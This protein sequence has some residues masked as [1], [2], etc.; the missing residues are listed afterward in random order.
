MHT[1]SPQDQIFDLGLGLMRARLVQV[2]AELRIA[3][4]LAA[5]QQSIPGTH[6][7]FVDRF[8]R[9]C[10]TIGLVSTQPDGTFRLT[11]VGETLR[12]G[13]PGSMQAM[14]AS[15]L[16]GAHL[17]A[18]S[19][20]R[21]SLER[22]VTA[23]DDRHGED[24]WSY[25]TKTNPDEGRLFN[26]AM[27]EFSHAVLP[28]ILGSF[29]FPATGTLVDVAGGNGTML[30][31]ALGQQPGLRG[32]VTD[33]AFTMPATEAYIA[34]Q[35]LSDRAT[36]V[37]A[38]FFSSVPADAETYMMKFILHDWNDLDA[39]RILDTIRAA[40]K[41]S[42]RLLILEQVVPEEDLPIPARIMDIN[43]M[44]MCGGK[45]RTAPEWS[46]LLSAHGFTLESITPTPSPISVIQ[47]RVSV[48]R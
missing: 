41:P 15:V 33:L 17:R 28:A 4:Y 8:L 47:A 36:A 43:M 39:G 2:F 32:I 13:V 40:A 25:F 9:A 16:G 21:A 5:G 26:Q 37:A 7:P 12:S 31:A 6:A 14:M 46:A 23:F 19:N 10:A 34:A 42:S 24:A 22:G 29:Q 38:D 35:G 11:P 27:S 20:L 45:E 18:W 48:R 1:L 44:V 3:D 30:C